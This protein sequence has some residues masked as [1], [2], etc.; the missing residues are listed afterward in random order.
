V[1]SRDELGQLGADFNRMAQQLQEAYQRELDQT[2][3]LRAKVNALLETVSRAAGGDLT[4]KVTV[5]GEDSIGR[6]GEGL[7]RMFDNLRQLLTNVQKAGIQVTTSATEIAA[8]AKQQEATGV[9]QAQTSVE[10]L[11][12]T[13]EISSNTSQLLKTMEDATAVADYTTSATSEAQ[14]NLRRMDQTMQNMVSTP[15]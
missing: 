4:A 6:L 9:E 2:N 13:K 12:T 11:S 5:T 3:D 15:S 10:V 1:T 7:Q 14:N 8:S